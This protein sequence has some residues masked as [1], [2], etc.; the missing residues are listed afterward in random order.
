M[1]V[2]LVSPVSINSQEVRHGSGTCFGVGSSMSNNCRTNIWRQ[3]SW[4]HN[5][6]PVAAGE[7]D[8]HR[9]AFVDLQLGFTHFTPLEVDILGAYVYQ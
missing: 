4:W 7:R 2:A 3:Q 6:I 8:S 5:M 9:S 1:V